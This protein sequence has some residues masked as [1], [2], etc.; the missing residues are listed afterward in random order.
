M[1]TAEAPFCKRCLLGETDTQEQLQSIRE[2]IG[3]LPEE[4]KTPPALYIARLETC[5][6]CDHLVAGTCARCGCFVELR[7]A[8]QALFCPDSAPK[9]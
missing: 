8:K 6:Q 4:Q 7:A 2:L 9:W 5:K 1:R 3:L